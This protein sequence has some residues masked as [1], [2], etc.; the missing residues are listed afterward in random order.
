[1]TQ[2]ANDTKAALLEYVLGVADDSLILGQ[3]VSEWLGHAP[4]MELDIA[5]SNLALDLIGQAQLYYEYAAKLQGE[6]KSADDLAFLRD[7]HHF[8]N[9]LLVEQ[10]NGDFGQTIVRHYLFMMFHLKRS[11]LL[12]GSDDKE[13][14]AIAAKTVRELE[15]HLRFSADWFRRLALGTDEGNRRIQDGLENLW[16]FTF[17]MFKDVPA[18]TPLYEAGTVPRPS[19]IEAGWNAAVADLLQEADISPSARKAAPTKGRIAGHHTEHLGH[20]L[21]EMQF[22]QRAYPGL[23]W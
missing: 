4:A 2:K 20:L 8:R 3:R 12:V 15:Y 19:G 5:C 21:A 14:A 18:E 22:L 6:G 1:M 7:G 9:H 11:E 16:S 17:E 13:L 23:S 10:P